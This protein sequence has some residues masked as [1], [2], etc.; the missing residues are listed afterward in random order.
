MACVFCQIIAGDLP[1]SRFYEDEL[2]LGIMDI[3]PIRPGHTLIIPKTHHARIGDVEPL[4]SAAMWQLGIRVVNAARA[5]LDADDAHLLLNDGPSAAQT[6]LHSHLHIIPRRSG[7]TPRLVGRILTK[8][9]G[10]GKAPHA[11]LERFTHSDPIFAIGCTSS[12]GQVPCSV[13]SATRPR[14]PPHAAQAVADHVSAFLAFNRLPH[15][16]TGDAKVFCVSGQPVHDRGRKLLGACSLTSQTPWRSGSGPSERRLPS[17]NLSRLAQPR[18]R[19]SHRPGKGRVA[20]PHSTASDHEPAREMFRRP[21]AG[22][23][24]S[25]G[26][27]RSGCECRRRR[28]HT[29]R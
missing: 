22:K 27:A 15:V 28:V 3:Q 24:T 12:C 13:P 25:R 20:Q 4:T 23:P 19:P 18:N 6:V 8:P 16:G 11:Q 5:V 7:D 26:I 10:A 17:G 29:P 9:A 1:A 21:P 2:L 14:C